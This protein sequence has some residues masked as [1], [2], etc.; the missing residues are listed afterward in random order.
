MEV[1][2]PDA[3]GM[4]AKKCEKL[5]QLS[6]DT[7][8][9]PSTGAPMSDL[10]AL[11]Q[12]IFRWHTQQL[13]VNPDCSR[14]G[15]EWWVQVKKVE[16]VTCDSAHD[17]SC[18]SYGDTMPI[19]SPRNADVEVEGGVGIDLHYDKDEAIA[20]SFSVGIFPIISTVTY[21]SDT[22]HALP[23]LI[24][25]TTAGNQVGVINSVSLFSGIADVMQQLTANRQ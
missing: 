10:E 25:E 4:L 24:F 5:A 21:L 6:K 23:T 18:G 3:I 12:S 7:F 16:R 22:P 2:D 11:A 9:V 15:A 20:S 19:Q 13:G 1:I 17:G 8:W 14:S